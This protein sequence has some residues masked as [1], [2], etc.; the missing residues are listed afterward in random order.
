M[1]TT[2]RFLP[3]HP[4]DRNFF[5][6]MLLAVWL[7]L[8]SGFGYD[9]IV[10]QPTVKLAFPLIVHFHAIVFVAWL[11]LFTVQILFIRNNNFKLHKK[12]GIVALPLALMMVVLG[13]MTALKSESVKFGT[14][15]ANTAFISIMFG[16][17]LVFAVLVS[18]AIY[19]K[20]S[21]SAHKRIM[22]IATIAL[23]DAGFGRC[24]S[25]Y[26]AP[27]FGKYYWT[28]TN[29]ADGFWPFFG[30]Q[31]IGPFTLMIFI[32]LYDLVTRGKL[33]PAYIWSFIWWLSINVFEG[34][35]YFNPEWLKIA[36]HL[37]GH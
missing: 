6:V 22:L 32:G 9:I 29:F 23:T 28:L 19:Y 8:I 2:K 1:D 31:I 27:L 16:D 3:N 4:W 11:V 10:F 20:K 24:I 7:A 18:A 34:W 35:L 5:L 21:P 15:Y 30:F 13:V 26:V 14:E 33:H 37:I 17:M 36:K 12:F 25:N